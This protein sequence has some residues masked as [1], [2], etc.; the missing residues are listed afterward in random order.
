MPSS[1][2]QIRSADRPRRPNAILDVDFFRRSGRRAFGARQDGPPLCASSSAR[3]S[4][5]SA[6][7]VRAGEG[8]VR[9]CAWPCAGQL[10]MTLADAN[11]PGL[12]RKG[13][14]LFHRGAPP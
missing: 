4:G 5:Q 7:T 9:E 2:S 11:R 13:D 1:C 3:T 14:A 12:H 8:L 10:Q 6:G